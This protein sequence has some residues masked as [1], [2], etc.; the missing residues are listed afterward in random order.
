[1]KTNTNN[2]KSNIVFLLTLILSMNLIS[3]NSISSN[4]KSKSESLLEEEETI[5]GRDYN[6]PKYEPKKQWFNIVAYDGKCLTALGKGRPLKE[7][8]CNNSDGAVWRMLKKPEGY[9]FFS[10]KIKL[11]IDSSLQM[12]GKPVR[13][14]NVNKYNLKGTIYYTFGQKEG[15]FQLSSGIYC[16]TTEKDQDIIM[17]TCNSWNKKQWF[18]FKDI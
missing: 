12:R 2:T 3:T 7:K 11:A 18:K 5:T 6:N 9:Q 8:E 15:Y 10:K 14:K 1:M 4:L 17:M 16:L 13:S